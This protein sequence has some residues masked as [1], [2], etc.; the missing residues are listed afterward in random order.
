V[1]LS[2]SVMLSPFTLIRTTLPGHD[3]TLR[4]ASVSILCAKRTIWPRVAMDTDFASLLIE[5]HQRR[6]T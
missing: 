5:E 3:L 4:A 2:R 1:S 6:R